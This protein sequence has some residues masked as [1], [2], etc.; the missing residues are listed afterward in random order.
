M[1]KAYKPSDIAKL[2]KVSTSAVERWIRQ[3]RISATRTLGGHYRIE[4]AEY[5]RLVEESKVG[6]WG[7]C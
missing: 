1:G 6:L 7:A 4:E 5:N 3:G 2:F